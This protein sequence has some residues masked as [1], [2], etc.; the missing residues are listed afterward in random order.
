M[1][2][3]ETLLAAGMTPPKEFTPGRWLRFPGI[4]KG[5]SNRSG[6]CR[7]ISPTLALYGDWS[8][9][10][11]AL[12]HDETHRDDAES[13]Q[14]L[15]EAREREKQFAR[16]QARRAKTVEREAMRMLCAAKANTHPYLTSKGFKH[17]LGL[18]HDGL[19]LIPIRAAEDYSRLIS[20][21]TIAQDGTK[22][23]LTGGRTKGGIHRLGPP[24][25]RRTA[26]CEGYATGLTLKAAFDLLPGPWMIVVC[27]SAAN[28][29]AVA[30]QFSEAI[31]C[32]DNDV[33]KAGEQAAKATGLRWVMPP[34]ISED[35]NDMH[36]RLGLIHVVECLRQA[37]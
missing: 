8:S 6:W 35:F 19:L 10:L 17:T 3:Q 15:R 36:Q 24:R 9:N 1:T 11:S 37:S 4:G 21:Q 33:S 25:A 28:L 13:R 22:R 32:A 14:L 12:W 34:E 2:L 18:V 26:L 23:F 29:T 20:M 5:R 27:F 30:P 7:V 31:V 16:E